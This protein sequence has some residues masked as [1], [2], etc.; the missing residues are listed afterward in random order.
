M[1]IASDQAM[2]NRGYMRGP[3]MFFGGTNVTSGDA[4]GVNCRG[5]APT[6]TTLRLLLGIDHYRQSDE[7]WFRLKSVIDDKDL[8]WQL[9]FIELVPTSIINNDTYSED[10]Y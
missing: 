5:E 3:Y 4:E 9:D 2:R 8:K 6:L 10:W 1:G 7:H